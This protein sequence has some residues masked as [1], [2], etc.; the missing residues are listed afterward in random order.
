MGEHP[1]TPSDRETAGTII[2]SSSFAGDNHH[3]LDAANTGQHAPADGHPGDEAPAG[4]V[5]TGEDVCPNCT[6]S[7]KING[8]QDC[9]I[10]DGTGIIIQGIGGG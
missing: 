4:T 1:L 10:C 2:G 9:P 6:G 7:G 8:S 3:P 5:G